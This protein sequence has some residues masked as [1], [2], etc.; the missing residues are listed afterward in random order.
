MAG[1][2]VITSGNVRFDGIIGPTGPWERL[3]IEERR[4]AERQRVD[5]ECLRRM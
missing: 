3:M 2:I 4:D 1:P 5:A